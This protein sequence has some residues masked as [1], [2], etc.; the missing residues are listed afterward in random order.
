MGRGIEIAY[1]TQNSKQNAENAIIIREICGYRGQ[2]KK[3]GG[4]FD[5]LEI[6]GD[7]IYGWSLMQ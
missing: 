2:R 6:Q 7:V 1:P 3:C 5:K 4:S